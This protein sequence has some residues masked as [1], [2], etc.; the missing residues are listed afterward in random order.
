MPK[1]L[2]TSNK[3][4]FKP[5]SS[6]VKAWM[7]DE[8]KPLPPLASGTWNPDVFLTPKSQCLEITALTTRLDWVDVV[9][10][11]RLPFTNAGS[12][13][14]LVLPSYNESYDLYVPTC[15]DDDGYNHKENSSAVC[16]FVG[17][18]SAD[19]PFVRCSNSST[20]FMSV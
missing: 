4:P 18:L 14:H 11:D 1:S 9:L 5:V 19:K 15:L 2:Y 17:D 20:G 8:F 3:I 10:G 7:G 12:G 16:A 6:G 13:P